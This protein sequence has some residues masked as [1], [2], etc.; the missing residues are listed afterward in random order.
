VSKPPTNSVKDIKLNQFNGV[1][2][3]LTE[4]DQTIIFSYI[5]SIFRQELSASTNYWTKQLEENNRAHW[6][7]RDPHSDDPTR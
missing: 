2:A 7:V 3:K 6:A 1:L 4:E 5:D